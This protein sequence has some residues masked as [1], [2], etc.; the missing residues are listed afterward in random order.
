MTMMIWC[1]PG[2]TDLDT[3]A[4]LFAKE[5]IGVSN[6]QIATSPREID[7]S[8]A[9]TFVKYLIAKNFPKEGMSEDTKTSTVTS[10][11]N[12][13]V[14]RFDGLGIG[15]GVSTISLVIKKV[16][17]EL[18]RG[19][20]TGM[21]ILAPVRTLKAHFVLAGLPPAF[22]DSG[23]LLHHKEDLDMGIPHV[24]IID[25]TKNRLSEATVTLH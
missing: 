12:V 23:T 20:N 6:L 8:A 18:G 19:E 2:E 5:C 3:L 13:R 21:L 11:T 9:Q 17:R 25:P 24:E 1:D 22:I 10:L 15:A 14:R 4:T 16:R 7:E